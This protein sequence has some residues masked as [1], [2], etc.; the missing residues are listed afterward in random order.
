MIPF[1]YILLVISSLILISI[2][3]SK[4]SENLGLPSLLL[5][6]VIGM[7]A[8]SEGLG[9]VY[10]DNFYIAQYVGIIALIFILFSGGLETK[11][12]DTKPVFWSAFSLSTL[13]VFFTAVIVG[14]LIHF[15]LRFGLSESLLIGAIISSTDAAAVFSVLR[16]KGTSLKNKLRLL[17]EFESG[18]NDPVAIILTLILISVIKT[19]EFTV[20]NI[21]L[22][23]I[24]QLGLGGIFG[25]ISGK[26]IAA[27]F[28]KFKFSYPSLY[29]VFAIA[30]SVFVYAVTTALQGS[31]ILAVYISALVIGS[32]EFI[33]KKSLIRFFDGL[34]LLGQ[35]GMF[36]TLGLLVFPSQVYEIAG[37]GLIISGL[38]IFIGRPLSVFIS[39]L[40]SKFTF[41]EKIFVSW[42]GL[43][44]AVPIILATFPVSAGLEIGPFIFN[45]IFFITIT[46]ALFQGWSIPFVAELM[47][48][49]API[50]KNQPFPIEL[51][52][53]VNLNNDLLDLI[54]PDN[55]VAI[56]KSLAELE[57]PQESLVTVIYRN[58][59]YIVPS[60]ST[61]IEAGDTILVLVNKDNIEKVK[62]TFLTIKNN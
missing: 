7:A 9:K 24:L 30:A 62:N 13:G 18:S 49:K 32:S 1:E 14:I 48:L 33:Q 51:T 19:G 20:Y 31:G 17:L 8:G 21:G 43:R 16:A 10:F 39:M 55:S 2:A 56:G 34:A 38:L 40:F 53:D 4:L 44:G 42:V 5:F 60:G 6:L 36:L 26:L 28:N 59:N 61:A 54:I 35:I 45:L 46:S 58:N 22:Y 23:L 27:A 25:Y 3:I 41:K 12:K 37:I 29:I 15:F 50:P 47:G 57:L 52:G 11:W